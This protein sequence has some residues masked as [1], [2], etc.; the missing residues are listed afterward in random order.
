MTAAI[1]AG[2]RRN[3]PAASAEEHLALVGMVLRRFPHCSAEKEELYQQGC[4]GLMKAI[5][6]FD[7]DHGVAFSTYAASMILGEMRMLR[8]QYEPIHIPRVEREQRQRIRRAEALLTQHLHRFPTIQELAEA[9]RMD[10]AELAL[11]MEE[12]SVVS[13]DAMTESGSP[14]SDLMPDPEDWQLR[15]ELRDLVARLPRQDMQLMLLRYRQGLSQ[16]ET[17]RRLGLTQVQ[18]SRREQRLRRLL[19]ERWYADDPQSLTTKNPRS[20]A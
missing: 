19:R 16:A 13:S 6:R 8:R 20:R 17:A 11:M 7:P 14:L 1:Q 3:D 15:I 10:A 4:I 5:S 2:V 9:L 18:V 12:V